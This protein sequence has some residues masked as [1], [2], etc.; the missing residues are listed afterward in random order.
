[1]VRLIS[2]TLTKYP[3]VAGFL[4][5]GSSLHW[6]EM[7]A[8]SLIGLDK[9]GNVVEE[10]DRGGGPELSAACIHIGT[11]RVRPEAKV[12]CFRFTL[13]IMYSAFRKQS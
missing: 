2:S 9:E 3:I 6:S 13:N 11:R 8:S 1:M 12:E 5:D 10:G 7:T 4:P